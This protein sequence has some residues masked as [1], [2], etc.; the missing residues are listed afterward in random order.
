MEIYVKFV[1]YVHIY[2]L[3]YLI[4]RNFALRLARVQIKTRCSDVSTRRNIP[5]RNE[6]RPVFRRPLQI[7]GRFFRRPQKLSQTA[8]LPKLRTSRHTYTHSNSVKRRDVQTK[9]DPEAFFV[10]AGAIII[11]PEKP[12]ILSATCGHIAFRCLIQLILK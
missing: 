1:L 6:G 7:F 9:A 4:R 5:A 12:I 3:I 2:G 10:P 8:I 11:F